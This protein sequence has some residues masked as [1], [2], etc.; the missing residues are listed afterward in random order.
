MRNKA[1]WDTKMDKRD[2]EPNAG[3]FWKKNSQSNL[4]WRNSGPDKRWGD[5]KS[6]EGKRDLGSKEGKSEIRIK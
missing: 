1:I 4:V 5:L 2:F 6:N 3:G